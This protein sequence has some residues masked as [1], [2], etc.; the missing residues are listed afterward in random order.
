MDK[1]ENENNLERHVSLPSEI[2]LLDPWDEKIYF[3]KI[4][5]MN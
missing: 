5:V 1:A 4:S 3:P 2:I